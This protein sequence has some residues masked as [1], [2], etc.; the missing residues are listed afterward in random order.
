MGEKL[1]QATGVLIHR[2]R[3]VA[4]ACDGEA[5]SLARSDSFSGEEDVLVQ[6][7]AAW[8]ARAN[9][10]WQA[11]ARLEELDKADQGDPV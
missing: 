5:D 3:R 6:R 2:L 8:R 7:V 1:P 4:T 11:A 9:T 10:C